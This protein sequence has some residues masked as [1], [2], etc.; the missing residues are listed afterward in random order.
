MTRI[1][2]IGTG[3]MATGLGTG[4]ARAGH[5]VAFGSR[6]PDARPDIGARIPGARVVGYAEALDSAEVVVIT[7]PFTAVEG[8][9]RERAAALRDKLVIDISN[10]FGNLPDN[11]ISGA[12]ITAAAIGPG[13]RVVAAFKGNFAETLLEPAH[14]TGVPRDVHYAGD[15]EED[16][17]IVRGLIEDLHFIAVDCGPLKNARVLDVLV[18]LIVE[19]DARYG[20][21]RKSSWKFLL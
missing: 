15:R 8:F 20:G 18:P 12:E 2:I 4:W 16:K 11:R 3:R 17:R 14:A 5:S 21:G 9:A 19:L 6:D 7:L 10:P 13:A 1:A